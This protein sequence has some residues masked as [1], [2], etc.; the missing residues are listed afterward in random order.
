MFISALM[1]L[2]VAA[3]CYGMIPDIAVLLVCLLAFVAVYWARRKKRRSH[4]GLMQ[5]DVIAQGSRLVSWNAGLKVLV[6][7]SVLVLCIAADSI[8]VAAVVLIGMTVINLIASRIR[9]SDYLSLL[10]VPL[11]FVT[12]SGWV[13]L[14]EVT[15]QP[16]GLID[17]PFLGI[18]L[19]ITQASQ[20]YAALILMKAIAALSCLY[21]LSLS[22]PVYE[23]TSFL[24][25]MR[26][27][28]IMV[29]LMV[30]I[31]RYVF[32]L[33]DSLY[34]MNT[35]AQAR[36]GYRTYRNSW[37]S[38]AGIASNLLVRSFARASRSFDAMEARAYRGEIRFLEQTKTITAVHVAA[39]V[40]VFVLPC[41]V[42]VVERIGL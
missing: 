37:R 33:L 28:S 38:F 29:E 34:S 4:T 27:P 3:L 32:V 19:S 10:M 31:Y 8:A 35:A 7:V 42:L 11:I 39:A 20:A 26:V 25:R 24:R 13:L 40:G 17:I 21:G 9:V 36:L 15:P 2:L 6:C 18:Y 41:L 30:L 14:V 12:L 1:T 16:L 22:T 5:I 23:I